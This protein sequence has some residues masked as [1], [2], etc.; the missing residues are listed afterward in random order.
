MYSISNKHTVYPIHFKLEA[1]QI[2]SHG[3][4]IHPTV[5]HKHLSFTTNES[6][7]KIVNAS[8]TGNAVRYNLN[9]LR[10]KFV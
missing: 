3:Y 2:Q 9:L 6:A 10:E 1:R 7:D 5:N 8:P 4:T